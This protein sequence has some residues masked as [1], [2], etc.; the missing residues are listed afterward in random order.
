MNSKQ[1]ENSLIY[2]AKKLNVG[3]CRKNIFEERGIYGSYF[4]NLSKK[5]K[6]IHSRIK[7]D[8]TPPKVKRVVALAHELGHHIA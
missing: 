4:F 8:K 2:L 1:V 5:Y 6:L 3:I 7:I